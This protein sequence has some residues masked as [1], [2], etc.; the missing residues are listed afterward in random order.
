MKT[1]TTI[2]VF[3]MTPN[4]YPCVAESGGATTNNREAIVWCDR[5]GKPLKPFY[6]P[7]GGHLCNGEHAFF[8]PKKGMYRIFV[9]GKTQDKYISV[10]RLREWVQNPENGLWEGYFN[11]VLEL[12]IDD[13][14]PEVQKYEYLR[15]LGSR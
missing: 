1:A 5:D 14:H 13:P 2:I 15:R 7:R 8:S 3:K 4:G 10:M 12:R 9:S 11:R 6:I